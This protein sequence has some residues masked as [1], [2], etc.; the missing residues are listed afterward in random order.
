[1]KTL[2][3]TVLLSIPAMSFAQTA[4]YTVK[5][6]IG[7]LNAPA[8]VY[9]SYRDNGANMLDSAQFNNGSFE[10]KGQIAGAA[11][12]RLIVDYKGEGLASLGRMTDNIGLLI[13][14]G[15]TVIANSPDSAKHATITGSKTNM[16]FATYTASLAKSKAALDALNKEWAAATPEERA[17][18]E[19]RASLMAR[20]EPI[21]EEMKKAQEAFIK[22]NPASHISLIALKEFAGR[23]IDYATIQP[24]FDKLD[25]H[26]KE[27]AGGVEFQK[28]L[29]AHKNTA[30]G[31][32][33]PDFTQNDVNDKPV[34]LSDFRGKYVLIDFWASWCGPCRQENP[35]VVKA[36]HQYKDKNF[37]VLGVSL[38]QP[39]KKDAWLAAI[40]K[41]Q[42]E[43][44][45]VSDLQ[46]WSNEAAKLYAVSAIP[47]NYLIDPQGKIIAKNLRAEGLLDKLAE[48]IK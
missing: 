22:S 8:Q 39:G 19:L 26:V 23:D 10:L 21:S 25:K 42:L 46:G 32:I 16:E 34:K 5:G 6:K 44:T 11:Q 27:S 48:I 40:E 20:N 4:P 28:T 15:E 33:A 36:F 12:A 17:G 3:A 47:Q 37:T 38:D 31:A 7:S 13:V 18:T 45:Q 2:I 43:W 41:D 1:M 14:G 29:D 9:L 35:N 24:I 30:I